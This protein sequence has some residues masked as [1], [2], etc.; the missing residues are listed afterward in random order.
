MSSSVRSWKLE[1]LLTS[2]IGELVPKRIHRV[3]IPCGATEAHGAAGVGTDTLI[4][5]GLALRIAPALN[6]LVAPAVAYGTLRTLSRYPGSVTLTPE[7]YTRLLVEIGTGL[8]DSGFR[9]LLFINGHSG[10]I[11]SIKAAAFELHRK[12]G[13]FALSYDWFRE[14]PGN[15]PGAYEALGGHSGTAETGLVLAIRPEAAPDG[16]WKK[17]DAG[18]LNPAIA[19]YPGPFPI[20]LEHEGE[21]FPDYDRDKAERFLD[22]VAARAVQNLQRVLDRWETLHR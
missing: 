4:P 18:I 17:E 16:Q 20:I 6:A 9:E 1:E 21:G 3:M 19:A 7:T 10:N 13:A 12:R 22:A 11:D 15:E 8:M 2:E 14:I 5:E